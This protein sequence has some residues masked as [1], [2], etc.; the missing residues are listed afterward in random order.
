MDDGTEMSDSSEVV[1][2]FCLS[3]AGLSL[4]GEGFPRLEK[5]SLIWCSNVSSVGLRSLAE[6]CGSLRSLDLQVHFY[7]NT[8]EIF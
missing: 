3:D 6:R 5:L 7:L 2:S 1:E 4:L 8:E